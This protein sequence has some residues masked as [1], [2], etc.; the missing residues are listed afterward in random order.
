MKTEISGFDGDGYFP[1]HWVQ[2]Y[3][4]GFILSLCFSA[5]WGG[6]SGGEAFKRF[7]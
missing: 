7:I 5:K 2:I 6:V 1:V 3:F 4:P